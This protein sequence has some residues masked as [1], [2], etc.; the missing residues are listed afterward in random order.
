MSD[1]FVIA[2]GGG[3]TAVIN[4]TVAGAVL[5]ARKRFPDARVLG[6]RHGVRGIRKGDLAELS[7]L[8]AALK[9]TPAILAGDF[10]AVPTSPHIAT[11]AEHWTDATAGEK[12]LTIPSESP[13]RKIDYIFYRP[14]NRLR[15]VE[16]KVLDEPV[17]SD[18]RPVLTVFELR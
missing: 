2:Q 11:I 9:D 5:E 6:A 18:H 14:K 16:S 8:T 1:V 17:A 13:N 3:P 4:Q 15:V 12:M 10:N 7:R